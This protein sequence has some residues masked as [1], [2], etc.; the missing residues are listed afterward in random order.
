MKKRLVKKAFDM[1]LGISLNE[2]R[3][4]C[5]HN[6]YIL[7]LYQSRQKLPLCSGGDILLYC[8]LTQDYEKFWDNFGKHLKLGCIED[9][10]NHKR[11]APLLRFF[12][13][14]SEND[15]ISL[16][17]YVENMKAEQKA[18]YYIASDS[19]TSAKNAPFLEKLMEKELEVTLTCK[20]SYLFRVDPEV[21]DILYFVWL[22]VLYLVEPIDEVAIQSLK[23]YKDKDFIDISKEDLDLGKCSMQFP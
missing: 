19:V 1:I 18:I 21:I 4:V 15:M 9:R 11:L 8:L 23:S 3:E 7:S 16:D 2:N 20:Y 10:E 22:Q 14:Q 13:S 17:E 6:S 5:F 12:S